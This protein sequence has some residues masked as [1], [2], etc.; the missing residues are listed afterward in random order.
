LRLAPTTSTTMMLALGDALA[1]SLLEKRGFTAEDFKALHPGGQL[2]RQLL[3]VAD[4]MHSGLAMPLVMESSALMDVVLEM[5]TKRLGCAGVIGQQGQLTGIITDGDLRRNIAL[6]N[7]TERKAEEI[8]TRTPKTVTGEVYLKDALHLMHS[9]TIT[10]VFV[11]DDAG[12][13]QGVV[14]LHDVVGGASI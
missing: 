11:L 3:C 6:K 8:M 14:H 2:G 12:R 10:C 4:V 1:I 13:P 9:H 5:T 7:F